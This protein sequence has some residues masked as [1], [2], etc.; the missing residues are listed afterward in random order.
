MLD[1]YLN[2][3]GLMCAPKV[4]EDGL[5][6]IHN[7][8][9]KKIPFENFDVVAKKQIDLTETALFHKLIIN[10]RGGYCFELNGLMLIMLKTLGFKA[11]ELLARV[12]LTNTPSG[13]SHQVSLVS[14]GNQQWI[15]D[16][17]FGSQT[18]R[19]PLLLE[20]N[21]ECKID[22]QIFRFIEVPLF[23]IMLQNKSH[24]DTWLD[25]YSFD[26]GHVCAN[27]IILGN[28]YTSTHPE[29]FF[30]SSCVAAIPTENGLITLSNRQLK[31]KTNGHLQETALEDEE[32]YF[33]ALRDNFGIVLD[34]P[35]AT[36]TP[37]LD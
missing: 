29:S 30:T 21:K 17:G 8:Q 12:H 16:A 1:A 28:H 9:H 23:G 27:D 13:R 33:K 32:S 25:L 15:V 22:Q 5:V 4:T 24:D 2:K 31:I 7:H 20:L 10:P 37:F 6:L 34:I 35:F 18:P 3:L 14:I 11:R 36:L 19:K 26:L